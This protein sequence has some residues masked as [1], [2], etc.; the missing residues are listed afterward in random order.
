MSDFRNRIVGHGEEAPD[1][2]LANP[3]N[4]RVHPKHQQDALEGALREVG[5][6]QRIIVNRTTGHVV[7]GHMRVALAQKKGLASVPVTYVE[8]SEREEA[9]IL[10]TLDPI[11]G[12][13]VAD[14]ETLDALLREVSTGDAALQSLLETLA[15]DS[16]LISSAIA[17]GDGEERE[18]GTVHAYSLV[19]DSEQQQTEF[20]DFLSWLKETTDGDTAAQRIIN[21][22]RSVMDNGD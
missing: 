17:G 11:S 8:L 6:V 15:V 20:Y 22:A 21:H 4:W 2:L 14:K 3:L 1:E 12:L 10:A 5:W 7:D 9:L 13:A 18:L 16:G 19:F